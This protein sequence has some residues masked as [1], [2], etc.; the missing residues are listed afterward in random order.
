[1]WGKSERQAEPPGQSWAAGNTEWDGSGGRRGT[2]FSADPWTSRP[3]K[4]TKS[5]H[6]RVEHSRSRSQSEQ[7]LSLAGS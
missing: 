3:G 4:V 7:R 1:M 2:A 6:A 5:D